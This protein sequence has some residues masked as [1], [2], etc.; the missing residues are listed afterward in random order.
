M[1]GRTYPKLNWWIVTAV[2]VVER[3]SAR[4]RENVIRTGVQVSK[5]NNLAFLPQARISPA[6]SHVQPHPKTD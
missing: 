5:Q 1:T 3:L 6:N 4:A 2:S